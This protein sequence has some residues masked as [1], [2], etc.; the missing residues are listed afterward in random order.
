MTELVDNIAFNRSRYSVKLL[1]KEGCDSL[2]S[3]YE[4]SLA[5][6]KGQVMKLRKEPEV[7]QEYDSVIKDQ[8]VSGVIERVAELEGSNRVH[9]IPHLAVIRKEATITKL[10]V[11]YDASAKQARGESR[12]TIAYTRDNPLPLYCSTFGLDS[13]R[14]G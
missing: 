14:K 8:L 13:E 10:R 2:D 12:S 7:L 11:V 3:N 4:L 5:R 6:M 1:W 9:Y